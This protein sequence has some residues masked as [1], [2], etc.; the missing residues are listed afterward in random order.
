[1][2]TETRIR[3]TA[4]A[5]GSSGNAFL[6]EAA[7]TRLLFDAG[8]PAATLEHYLRQCGTSPSQ[9]SAIF[10]S[11]EHID[12]LRGA[13]MLARRYRLPVVASEGTFLAGAMQLGSLP[14]KLVQPPGREVYVGT[15]GAD[16]VVVRTFAV[17]HD[18]AEPVGFWIE[19]GGYNIVLC[20][21]LGC[22]TASI[23]D[24]LE[25]ADLLVIEAN[26][27]VQRLWRGPY[28][29][30]LKRR[31]AGRH[32]HLAND[33]AARLVSGLARDARPRTVWL[34]HLSATNNTPALAF[35]TVAQPLDREGCTH[36]EVAVLA[37]DKPSHVWQ[38]AASPGE[39][40]ATA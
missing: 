2:E 10:V 19:A 17:S 7:G 3:V 11:H 13:G 5:S 38:G 23:R 12:H 37:R 4:L 15:D 27:D 35:D 36:L 18:A 29:P 33:D 16:G 1:M 32:G 14:E 8:L 30:R 40:K 21:D 39:V 20:T 24:A 6:I 25:A 26:H 22:E 31:V 9:L 34:A 28:P